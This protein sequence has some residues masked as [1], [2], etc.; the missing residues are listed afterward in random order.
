VTASQSSQEE[1]THAR[2]PPI[3]DIA[4]THS[5]SKSDDAT[6]SYVQPNYRTYVPGRTVLYAG[7]SSDQDVNLLRHLPFDEAQ[8]FGTDNWRVWKAF[9]HETDPAYFTVRAIPNS[10]CFRNRRGFSED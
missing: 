7:F 3:F 8:S 4:G 5:P 1:I 6:T 10:R 9:P 2:D